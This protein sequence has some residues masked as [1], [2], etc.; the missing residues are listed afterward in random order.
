M[1]LAFHGVRGEFIIAVHD[2]KLSKKYIL[3]SVGARNFGLCWRREEELNTVEL[4]EPGVFSYNMS[5]TFGR[6]MILESNEPFT[7]RSLYRGTESSM[8]Y[9]LVNIAEIHTP[10]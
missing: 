7:R 1:D 10:L 3:G 9:M 8:V 5:S 6:Q 4:K 2:E